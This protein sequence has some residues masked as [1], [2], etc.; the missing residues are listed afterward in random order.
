MMKPQ[1]S[2]FALFFGNR[3]FFPA[4]LIAQARADLPRTLKSWG[5][6]T[7]MLEESATRYGAVETRD[8][9]ERF[10]NF[11]RQ[12][13]GKYDGVI[14]SLPNFGDEFG[15]VTALKEAN[16]PIFIQAYPDEMDKMGPAL[17]R[18]SFCGK[19]SIMDVFQQ[20]DVKFTALKPH[21]VDPLSDKFKDNMDYFDR[22][23]RVVK[24]MKQMTV[25]AIGARTT[26]FKT[27]RIDEVALQH[28]GITVETVD[29]S[30]VIARVKA[31]SPN[32]EAVRAKADFFK[33]YTSWKTVPAG[34]FENLVKLGVVL[35]EIIQS[36]KLDAMAIRCWMELQKQL[37]I[38]PC[39]LMGALNNDMFPAACE[40]DLGSAVSMHM[41]SLAS[42]QPPVCLDWNN[43]YD[44]EDDKCILFHCGPA[45]KSMM[46]DAGEVVDHAI[47]ATSEGPGCSYGPNVG[48]IAPMDFTFANLLTTAGAVNVYLGQGRFTADPIPADFFGVAGVAEIEALQD[49][50]LYIGRAGHRH[51]VNL[52]QGW[53][54]DPLEE[55]LANYLGYE[56]DLPQGCCQ[57]GH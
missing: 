43:N 25:G 40:V 23:C 28:R 16:V 20:F 18:D 26:P 36:Y 9:G 50:L 15:A 51:H 42:G 10:A 47:I 41:V 56:V 31:M 32:A 53:L 46:V 52:T 22:V 19:L 24:G 38:S 33:N 55:A 1:K 13:H 54:Q 57:C 4:S 44:D 29:M 48:R 37:G 6:D 7:L 34:A 49:I 2:T 39:V 14:V 5:H 35:D 45:P 12:N 17:R 30:E 8:E 11:L 21:V 3:G 27:V